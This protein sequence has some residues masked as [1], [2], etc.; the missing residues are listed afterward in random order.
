MST[1]EPENVTENPGSVSIKPH[2]LLNQN[3]VFLCGRSGQIKKEETEMANSFSSL[4]T[5]A[6][7]DKDKIKRKAFKIKVWAGKNKKT[8]L[9]N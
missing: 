7:K 5:N 3:G 9:K 1:P 2:C 4:V 6:E 8:I